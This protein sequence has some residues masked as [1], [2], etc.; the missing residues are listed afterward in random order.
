[1]QKYNSVSKD[2]REQ[3]KWLCLFFTKDQDGFEDCLRENDVIPDKNERVK[4]GSHDPIF[5]ANYCSN[6]KKLTMRIN[7]SMSGNNERKIIGIK[8]WIV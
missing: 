3:V 7:I 6:S 8:K 4:V 5:E 2:I 1:M